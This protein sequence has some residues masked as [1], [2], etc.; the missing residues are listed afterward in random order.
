ML[1]GYLDLIF[2]SKLNS[3]NVVN[4]TVEDVFSNMVGYAVGVIALTVFPMLMLYLVY[5][6][7][8]KIRSPR[9]QNKYA[10]MLNDLK[11]WQPM[12]LL[13]NIVFIGRRIL[14]VFLFLNSFLIKY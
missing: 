10:I 11:V 14:L 13:A 4:D 6:P 1:E 3:L 5:M 2:S 12:A 8:A 9:T 7:L